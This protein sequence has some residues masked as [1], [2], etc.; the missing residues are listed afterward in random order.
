MNLLLSLCLRSPCTTSSQPSQQRLVARQI[1]APS[2]GASRPHQHAWN[3]AARRH[4][5]VEANHAD[6][7]CGRSGQRCASMH[8]EHEGLC[9]RKGVCVVST[10]CVPLEQLQRTRT[11]P[12][13]ELRLTRAL[14]YGAAAA[15]SQRPAVKH[16]LSTLPPA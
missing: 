11:V 14:Q 6:S 9:R 5:A 3:A 15:T 13:D 2:S 12:R 4:D 8:S 7:A 1:T 10:T 16:L